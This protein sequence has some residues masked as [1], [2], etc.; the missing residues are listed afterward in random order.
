MKYLQSLSKFVFRAGTRVLLPALFFFAC[1]KPSSENGTGK[2]MQQVYEIDYAYGN[3][4]DEKMDIF[5]PAGDRDTMALMVLVHG[6]SWVGGDKSDLQ[7]WFNY[8]RTHKNLAVININYRLDNYYTCP[9]PMQ[10]DDI[11]MAIE[12]LREDFSFPAERIALLGGSA[13]GH[14]VSYYAYT[15]DNARYVKAVANFVG[16]VDFTDPVYHT[17]DHFKWIFSGIEYIFNLEYEGNEQQYAGWSPYTHASPQS[18]PTILLYGEQDTLVPYTN[19]LRMHQRLDS[20]GVE[21]AFHLYPG[22]GHLFNDADMLDA[23]IKAEEFMYRHLF[24]H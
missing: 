22:S 14:L 11:D 24:Q 16:P 2:S 8:E 13:G 1:K 9:L 12:K 15:Y 18:P 3:H 10:T 23:S 6:G 17:D 19:G 20:L 5:I 21:N 4:P 7:D